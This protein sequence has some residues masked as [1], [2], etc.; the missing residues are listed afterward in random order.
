MLGSVTCELSDT[1]AAASCE[2]QSFS[3]APALPGLPLCTE[4]IGIAAAY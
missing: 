3:Q 4:E 1:D 2:A